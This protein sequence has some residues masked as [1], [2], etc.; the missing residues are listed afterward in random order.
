MADNVTVSNSS[1][2]SNPD[3]PVRST[4][5][6]A[7]KHIQHMLIDSVQTFRQDDA[8]ST[9]SYY[10]FAKVGSATSAASWKIMKHTKTNPQSILFADGDHEYDNI[11]DNRASLSY[12]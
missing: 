4:E 2:S 5:T 12:S 11:W 7:G 10:G 8:S 1:A 6:V 9:V 3:I